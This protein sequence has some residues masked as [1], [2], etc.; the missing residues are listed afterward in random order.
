M[1]SPDL[2]LSEPTRPSGVYELRPVV[3]QGIIGVPRPR[4]NAANIAK[5]DAR[6]RV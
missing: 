6:Q 2:I 1:R 3:G 4:E 5:K